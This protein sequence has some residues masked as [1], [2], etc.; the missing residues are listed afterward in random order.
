MVRL[1]RRALIGDNMLHSDMTT[2][3]A[4]LSIAGF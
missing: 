1:W 4:I 2:I 3:Y